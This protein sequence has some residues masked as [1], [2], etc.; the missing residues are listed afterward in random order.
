M[1]KRASLSGEWVE[2]LTPWE[3]VTLISGQQSQSSGR[4][5]VADFG[6]R[7]HVEPVRFGDHGGSARREQRPGEVT[8]GQGRTSHSDVWVI[9]F[10]ASPV[11]GGDG[12]R[13]MVDHAAHQA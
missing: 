12:D 4:P 10:E 13:E 7:R 8:A 6:A 9:E 2:H 11:E 5:G 3:T 1:S